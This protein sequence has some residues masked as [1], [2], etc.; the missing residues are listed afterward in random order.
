VGPRTGLD[1]E[2]IGKFLSPLSGV[3]PRS[4]GRPAPSQTRRSLSYPAHQFHSLHKVI[5]AD[6]WSRP[7][8]FY[9]HSFLTFKCHHNPFADENPLLLTRSHSL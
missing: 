8:P 4:P 7:Q 3:E 6:T 5:S 1:T 2:A 9:L